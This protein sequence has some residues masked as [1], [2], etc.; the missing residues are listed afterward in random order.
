M[1]QNKAAVGVEAK[2]QERLS[3]LVICKCSHHRL[4]GSPRLSLIPHLWSKASETRKEGGNTFHVYFRQI[5]KEVVRGSNAEK[6]KS[7]F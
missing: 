3:G 7:N 4:L 5:W 1:S 2:P 6:E